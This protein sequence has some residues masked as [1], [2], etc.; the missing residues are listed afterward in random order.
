M[1][2]LIRLVP[3]LVP[4]PCSLDQA[5]MDIGRFTALPDCDME[6]DHLCYQTQGAKHCV[7]STF[8]V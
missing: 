6:G 4:C 2:I 1:Q 7:L 5:L 8:S 3:F